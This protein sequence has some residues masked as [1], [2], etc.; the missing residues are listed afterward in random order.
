M[1]EYA[2]S[3]AGGGGWVHAVAFSGDGQ[4]LCWVGHDSSVSAVDASTSPPAVSKLR[5]EVLP[6][7]SCVWVGP[8]T[9]VAAGHSCCPML[10]TLDVNGQLILNGKLDV[11]Q[12]REAG[13][14][15][16]LQ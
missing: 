1:A 13:G 15:R 5:T 9:L 4:R 2:N 10:Y 14:L 7:L 3:P 6:F 8:R 12:K 16:Y 11:S